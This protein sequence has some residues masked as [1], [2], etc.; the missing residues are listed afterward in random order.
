MGHQFIIKD[1]CKMEFMMGLGFAVAGAIK[2]DAHQHVR[3]KLAELINFTEFLKSSLITCETQ[4]TES[5]FGT[6]VPAGGPVMSV[7]LMFLEHFKR[8]CEI[9]QIIS[10][11]GLFMLPSFAEFDGERRPDVERFYQAANLDSRS[12]IKLFRLAY[13]AAGSSFS[14]R[15]QL[16]ERFFAANPVRAADR[17]YDQYDKAP[18]IRRIHDMLSDMEDG[19]NKGPDGP[20]FTKG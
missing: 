12:R 11:G 7:R 9:I 8:S 13:D 5:G 2:A 6:L 10:A 1:L 4:A 15:Q 3:V 16:Y 18:H 14:G 19:M 17:L 20:A